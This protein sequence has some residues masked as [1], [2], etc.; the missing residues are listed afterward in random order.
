MRKKNDLLRIYWADVGVYVRNDQVPE[1][2]GAAEQ[3]LVLKKVKKILVAQNLRSRKDK[4]MEISSHFV[5]DNK[6]SVTHWFVDTTESLDATKNGLRIINEYREET[7][8]KATFKELSEI[9][10]MSEKNILSANAEQAA[11]NNEVPNKR[12]KVLQLLF[13]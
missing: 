9:D 11:L 8:G 6:N 2:G 13:K 5:H 3:L 7:D 4:C 12:N 10:K 1:K